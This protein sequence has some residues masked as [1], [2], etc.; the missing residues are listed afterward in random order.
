MNRSNLVVFTGTQASRLLLDGQRCVGV[1]VV[2]DGRPAR[3]AARGE[4]ILA[5]GAVAT[6]QLLQ[7]SGIGPAALLGSLGIP[8][9]R[10]LPGVGANLQD[11]LPLRMA[12]K[13]QG[14]RTLNTLV[15]NPVAKLGMALQYAITR[16]GPLTMSPS[17]L[18]A[19]A[20]SSADRQRA[21]V[22][23]HVQP[24]SL[25]KFGEPLHPFPAFT[26]SVCNL[27][28]T[29]RGVIA[30]GSNDPGVAP[31]IAP[32]YLATEE[33]RRVAADA[34]RLTRRIV[35]SAALARYSPQ[36]FMPGPQ[37]Q[38]DAEL[39]RAAGEVGT[40]IFHPVG[41]AKMGPSSDPGA[42]V[43]VELRVHGICALQVIDASIMP[44]ITSGNTNSPTLMIAEKGAEFVRRARQRA[45]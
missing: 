3:I 27:R 30:I 15:S 26:A 7:L 20:M 40:T 41:T 12:F 18:G 42:V 43:D 13:V 32:N 17:Q 28:P 38:S 29:S 14:V 5:A 35:A 25:D 6:P 11:H 36:E 22:E 1:E 31:K 39:A 19:F 8:V 2:R 4:V 44:T 23:Y 10:D 45:A 33:D 24:L 21:N 34:L 37:F 9:R 16:R